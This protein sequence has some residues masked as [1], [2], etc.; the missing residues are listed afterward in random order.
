MDGVSLTVADGEVL[1]LLGPTGSGK[2]TVLRLIAGLESATAGQ[3]FFDGTDV[4]DTPA[5]DRGIALVFQDYALYPHLTVADNIGFPLMA[6]DERRQRA[7]RVAEVASLLGL[8][9]LLRRRPGQLSGGQRQ[10]VALGRAIARMPRALLMDQPLASLDTATRD[11]VRADAR[12]AGPHA[13]RAD[14]LRHP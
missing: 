4:Q 6:Q 12:G 2:S 9:A 13:R 1:V 14:G 7:A 8:E 3:I 5:Q 11:A 10:R